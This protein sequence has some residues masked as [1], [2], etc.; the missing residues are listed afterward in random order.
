MDSEL[1]LFEQVQRWRE[2][3]AELEAEIARQRQEIERLASMVETDVDQA[4]EVDR[5]T[6]EV[7]RLSQRCAVCKWGSVYLCRIRSSTWQDHYLPA[8][9]LCDIPESE[10]VRFQPC[11]EEA[12]AE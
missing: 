3:Y 5:L 11:Q 6:K 2:A 8:S 12:D 10:S 7:K 4:A 1:S 9:G